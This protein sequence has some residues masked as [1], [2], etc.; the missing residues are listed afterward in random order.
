MKRLTL[1]FA[2]AFFFTT[3]CESS[4]LAQ[5]SR[6]GSVTPLYDSSDPWNI[7]GELIVGASESGTLT[8]E[9]SSEVTSGSGLISDGDRFRTDIHGVVRVAGNE[10]SWTNTGTLTVGGSRGAGTLLVIEDGGTVSNTEGI[11]STRFR[12]NVSEVV[13]SGNGSKWVNSGE[14]TVAQVGTGKLTIEAGGVVSNTKGDVGSFIGGTGIVTVTGAGSE[15]NNSSVLGFGTVQSNGTILGGGTVN[16]E[17]GGV[18]NS[19]YIFVGNGTLNVR[20]GGGAITGGGDPTSGDLYI[21]GSS[22]DVLGIVN[23]SGAQ[24]VLKKASESLFSSDVVVDGNG[25]LN[26]DAEGIV[27]SDRGFIGAVAGQAAVASVSTG[28]QWN[29][30]NFLN[31]SG[32]GEARLEIKDGGVVSTTNGGIVGGR[33][34]ERGVVLVTGDRSQWNS[35]GGL[36][37]G[38]DGFIGDGALGGDGIL[39][40]AN[41]G[42]VSNTFAEIGA[43]TGD[44]A[45]GETF[46][47]S[48]GAVTVSGLGSQWNN[49]E[50]LTVGGGEDV[51]GFEIPIG[52]SGTLRVEAGGVVSSVG[53]TIGGDFG[54]FGGGIDF[55]GTISF[56]AV[57]VTGEESQWNNSSDLT[58]KDTGFLSIEDGGK[59][60]T[61]TLRVDGEGFVD[62]Q[63]GTLDVGILD[64]TRAVFGISITDGVVDAGEVLGDLTQD[65]GVLAPGNSPGVTAINGDYILNDGVIEIELAGTNSATEFDLVDVLQGSATLNG[66]GLNIL[67]LDG[68]EDSILGSDTFS[69]LN[70]ENGLTGAFDGFADGSM[71]QTADGLGLFQINYLNNSVVLSNFQAVAVPEPSMGILL[72]GL[73][74]LALRRRRCEP[75]KRCQG[76]PG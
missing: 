76:V 47:G 17:A 35:S 20:S 42:V 41:G 67:F 12:S 73:F 59:V 46:S 31:V 39:D 6:T 13:V 44:G 29:M 33:F 71:I 30:S 24:S 65:G 37:I 14:L 61:D 58:I 8:I 21:G 11:I 56:G 69:I 62:I 7:D 50:R 63:G 27:S 64:L 49:S 45:D 57:T 52:G 25:R 19:S 68:F 72:T 16:V 1:C 75:R 26:V 53:S 23:V 51:F 5:I 15:W 48:I 36:T 43:S 18:V 28:G 10:A 22:D 3:F 55:G 40:I 38:G 34:G 2:I 60:T 74:G 4:I 70:A 66:G 9:G 54:D 32:A